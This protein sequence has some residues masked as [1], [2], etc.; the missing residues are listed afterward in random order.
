MA[1]NIPDLIVS[2]F[3]GIIPP[4]AA[5]FPFESKLVLASDVATG[6]NTT[7]VS[8]TGMSFAYEANSAYVIDMYMMVQS[9]A[10]T[11]GHGF[12]LDV[13]TA[14]NQIALSFYNQLANTGTLTGG[15]STA[16]DASLG[17]SSGTP[18][19]AMVPV[20]GQGLLI[21]GANPGTAQFRF[22]SETTTV[23]TCKAGSMIRILKMG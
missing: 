5:I 2:L 23:T 12:Q 10:A 11:T 15:S 14:G 21:T 18:T 9:G 19:T 7:P 13:T 22:R 4:E 3:Q 6:A 8:L 16:D 20:M 17:V 1:I